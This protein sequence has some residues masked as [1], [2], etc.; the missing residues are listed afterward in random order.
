VLESLSRFLR[1]NKEVQWYTK[2][3][4]IHASGSGL[5]YDKALDIVQNQKY[6]SDSSGQG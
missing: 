3:C 1:Q 5:T 2:K 4:Q 6:S